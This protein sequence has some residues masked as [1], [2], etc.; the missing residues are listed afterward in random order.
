MM[1]G[2]LIGLA[3]GLILLGILVVLLQDYGYKQPVE[4]IN[5]VV[6]WEGIGAIAGQ[7][8][9]LADSR[10]EGRAG[11]TYV[12]RALCPDETFGCI[13]QRHDRHKYF[14]GG[15][16]AVS[17]DGRE[18]KL[19]P[20]EREQVRLTRTESF[21]ILYAPRRSGAADD[22]CEF[23]AGGKP[24][25]AID[26]RCHAAEGLQ[27]GMLRVWSGTAVDFLEETGGRLGEPIPIRVRTT[28]AGI[29][30]GDVVTEY[31]VAIEVV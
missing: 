11:W 28:T 13:L 20:G 6:S 30:G 29:D 2:T 4:V 3:A 9:C 18:Y 7:A 31:P 22:A 15:S 26:Q 10:C 8:E 12:T 19:R 14:T 1:V 17:H 24:L 27:D 16:L 21:V 5:E 23:A 25:M